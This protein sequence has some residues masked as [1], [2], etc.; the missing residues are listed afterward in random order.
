LPITELGEHVEEEVLEVLAGGEILLRE[1]QGL[2]AVGVWLDAVLG[3]VV[4]EV[5]EIGC[6]GP[7]TGNMSF[8]VTAQ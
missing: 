2:L 1:D 6:T 3:L 7:P 8:N 5:E 4:H